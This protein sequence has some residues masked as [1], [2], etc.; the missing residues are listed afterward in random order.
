M[1]W[2]RYHD[3]EL[4]T[5]EKL[6]FKEKSN[7]RKNGENREKCRWADHGEEWKTKGNALCL[8]SV[9]QE[10]PRWAN[11]KRDCRVSRENGVMFSNPG[12][13]AKQLCGV[14]FPTKTRS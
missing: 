7:T 1:K 6:K 13:E 3:K 8:M 14:C 4:G 11:E 5:G 12:I 9:V 2:T 10:I